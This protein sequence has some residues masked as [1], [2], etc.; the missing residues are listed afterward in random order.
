MIQPQ[1]SPPSLTTLCDWCYTNSA[2]HG[3]WE[4][5]FETLVHL[6]ATKGEESA[7]KYTVDV[8][9]S[10][11][12][13]ISSEVAEITEGVRKPGPDQ[14]CPAFTQEEI[15]L[16]DVLIRCFDYAG[17]FN[18]RLAEAVAAKMAYN[19]SRPFKHGKAA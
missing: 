16:A 17:A 3:F 5:Y 2:A 9:L 1:Y 18:L 13:L 10:K 8:K 6:R 7:A 11:H 19:A 14:H 4:D 12:A 15:E